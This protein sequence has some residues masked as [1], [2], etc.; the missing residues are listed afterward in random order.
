MQKANKPTQKAKSGLINLLIW[1]AL[2]L[3]NVST[4]HN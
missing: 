3:L 1:N 2:R 4:D